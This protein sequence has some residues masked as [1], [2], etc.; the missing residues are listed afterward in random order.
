MVH[1]TPL[2]S[3]NMDELIMQAVISLNDT[4]Y[5]IGEQIHGNKGSHTYDVPCYRFITDGYTCCVTFDGICIWDSEGSFIVPDN[6]DFS[7]R[8]DILT[9]EDAERILVVLTKIEM[10]KLASYVT[11]L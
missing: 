9:V 7:M 5:K 11:L 2:P 3:S 4:L 1:S 6:E 10:D 8:G